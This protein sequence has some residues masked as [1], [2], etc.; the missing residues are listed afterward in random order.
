MRRLHTE[1]LEAIDKLKT[2]PKP[3]E[4]SQMIKTMY[5]KMFDQIQQDMSPKDLNRLLPSKK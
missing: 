1:Y 2:P 3:V 4:Q 5:P